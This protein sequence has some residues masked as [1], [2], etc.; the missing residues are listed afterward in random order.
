MTAAH[1]ASDLARWKR[2]RHE[3]DL[4][5]S[6]AERQ[7]EQTRGQLRD[8]TVDAMTA[9][10]IAAVE[11]V[12]ESAA[13]QQAEPPAGYVVIELESDVLAAFRAPSV[14]GFAG[15]RDAVH[16]KL[17]R[18]SIADLR[19]L[20]ARIASPQP[21]DELAG[22]IWKLGRTLRQ[23]VASFIENVDRRKARE[24]AAAARGPKTDRAPEPETVDTTLRRAV[25]GGN[26]EV[27]LI[28]VIATLD[29]GARR[30]LATRLRTYRPG[31]GDD[32]AAR[33]MALDGAVRQRVL[34]ELASERGTAS[35]GS[36]LAGHPG[37]VFALEGTAPAGPTA[38]DIA[39]QVDRAVELATSLIPSVHAKPEAYLKQHEGEAW[40]VVARYL[41]RVSFP[42]PSPRAVWRDDV[43]FAA[44]TVAKLR[45]MHLFDRREALLEVLYPANPDA[46]LAALVPIGKA[47]VPTVGSALGQLFEQAI[48]A[49]LAR[50]GPR[51]VDLAEHHPEPAGLA[52]ENQALVAATALI[53]SAPIDRAVREGMTVA[54]VLALVGVTPKHGGV[55]PLRP[56]TLEWQGARDPQMWNWV[57]V[58][59]PTDATAEEVAAALWTSD[60][61]TEHA[62]GL[63]VSGSFF[64]VPASWA[65]QL[66]A[67]KAF[68]PAGHDVT[69]SEQLVHLASGTHAD[70]LAL[71]AAAHVSRAKPRLGAVTGLLD[72]V[73]IQL[74]HLVQIFAPW[75]LDA[76]IA[77][78]I[79]WVTCKQ[80]ELALAHDDERAT[81][82]PII[83]DQ[84]E[85][86]YRIADAVRA[87]AASAKSA[88][89][90]RVLALYARATATSFLGAASERLITSAV[91]EQTTLTL[92]AVRASTNDLAV[93][94]GDGAGLDSTQ[95]ARAEEIASEARLLQTGTLAGKTLD[96]DDVRTDHALDPGARAPSPHRADP[97]S[98][99]RFG[100]GGGTGH[101]RK[102]RARGRRLPGH[103]PRPR[104]D[105]GRVREPSAD[106]RVVVDVR[107]QRRQPDPQPRRVRPPDVEAPPHGPRD[108]AGSVRDDQ[109]G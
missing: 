24:R 64:G 15:R 79:H 8:A 4:A 106:G 55:R 37:S 44:A 50:L 93:V 77:T 33:F 78:A 48:V 70:E 82:A 49:S 28:A 7:V 5:I 89:M 39:T 42:S 36:P 84:K 100:R 53:S 16:A 3:A 76:E 34:V 6:R 90:M 26:S 60:R 51:W 18:L 108:R 81:W 107:R 87:L 73:R 1:G 68:A 20:R 46:A 22:E 101:R 40:E 32:I 97:S 71:D 105:D 66:A 75:G 17:E 96:P 21:E 69:A 19:V 9:L 29:G 94:V 52:D 11:L 99:P 57:R 35:M 83:A 109:D 12:A 25:E 63:T 103:V 54:G 85:R 56:V 14:A 98:A 86:V 104:T 102:G 74:A 2:A 31:S 43:A 30:A 67:A 80:H 38:A 10:E 23:E 65:R 91:Q 13:I 88:P 27:E 72:D 62:Y 59:S 58:S 92:G 47:W 45:G 61:A 41:E 95:V